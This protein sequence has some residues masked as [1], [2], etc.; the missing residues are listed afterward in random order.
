MDVFCGLVAFPLFCRH[1]LFLGPGTQ[2][3]HLSFSTPRTTL[4]T[5]QKHYVLNGKCPFL[6]QA[7]L[8]IW[9]KPT[10]YS[11]NLCPPKTFAIWFFGGCFWVPFLLFFL[12][13]RPKAP[14]KSHIANVLGRHRLDEQSG[15]R[16]NL[17][18]NTKRIM[19]G[20]DCF[21]ALFRKQFPPPLNWLKSGVSRKSGNRIEVGEKWVATH[22]W[23]IFV[24]KNPLLDPFKPIDKNPS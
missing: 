23:P 16:L 9:R 4:S 24:P 7:I 1:P 18:K 14:L 19:L 15:G 13:K 3:Q 17:K 21:R 12:Y 8:H 5:L 6:M 22:F 20:R 2:I 10:D 11:S